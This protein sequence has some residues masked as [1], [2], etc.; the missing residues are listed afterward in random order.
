MKIDPIPLSAWRYCNSSKPEMY[1]AASF[2]R[3]VDRFVGIGKTLQ[4][5]PIVVATHV[6]KSVTL[7]VVQYKGGGVS[8][9][10]RDNFHDINMWVEAEEPLDLPMDELFEV[11]DFAWYQ[12]QIYRK[13]G[14]TFFGWTK[15]E[16]DDP[17]ILRVRVYRD[18]GSYYWSSVSGEEKDRWAERWRSTEWFGRDWSS[19]DL[20]ASVDDGLAFDETTKFHLVQRCYAEGIRDLPGFHGRHYPD[21]CKS[22]LYCPRDWDQAVYV[23]RMIFGVNCSVKE[24]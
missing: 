22:F 20:I 7:P 18:N 6:S 23:A 8:I 24:S 5:R 3:Q 1:Y 16:M 4:A 10:F 2:D 9:A 19:A 14:Y 21:D 13:W 11:K 12:D 15:E 17:R